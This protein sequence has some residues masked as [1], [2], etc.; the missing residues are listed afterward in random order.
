MTLLYIKICFLDK[1]QEF[2]GLKKSIKPI[3]GVLG[4]FR[5]A[6][7]EAVIEY[8]FSFSGNLRMLWVFQYTTENEPIFF[9]TAGDVCSDQTADTWGH[10]LPHA[11]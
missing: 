7:A 2:L 4:I 1:T 5:T 8:L 10:L 3:L 9:L 11:D 6:C